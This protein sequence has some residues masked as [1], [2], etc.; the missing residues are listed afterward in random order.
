MRVG[1]SVRTMYRV[2][3]ANAEVRERRHQRRH[4]TYRK[5]QLL[6][7]APNDVWTWDLTK[8]KGPEKWTYYHLYVMLD[9]FSRYIVAWMLAHRE[10]GAPA[11]R[12]GRD[13]ATHPGRTTHRACRPGRGSDR[14]DVD[15][16]VCRSGDRLLVVATQRLQR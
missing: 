11:H 4:G 16:T 1:S 7:T 10:S 13:T 5:T 8:L 9:L 2:L 6:A 15:A 3:A 12:P 14:E